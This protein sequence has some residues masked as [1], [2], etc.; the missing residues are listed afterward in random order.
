MKIKKIF[1]IAVLLTAVIF[2]GIDLYASEIEDKFNELLPNIGAADLS[3]RAKA[4]DAWQ[5]ICLKNS[6]DNAKRTEA[7]KLMINQLDKSEVNGETAILFLSILGLVGDQRAVPTI[8]KFLG[9]REIKFVDDAFAKEGNVLLVD[10]AVRALARIPGNQSAVALS[11][12]NSIFARSGQ[13]ARAKKSKVK[14]GVETTMPIAIPYASSREVDRYLRNFASQS[15]VVKTQ[16]I[17]NL[18]VRGDKKYAGLIKQSIKSESNEIRRAAIAAA[19]MVD[20]DDILDML[21]EVLLGDDDV[22]ANAVVGAL[23]IYANQQVNERL[24]KLVE[25]EKDAKRFNRISEVLTN[26]KAAGFLPLLL[27]KLK[28]GVLPDRKS[29]ISRVSAMATAVDLPEFVELWLVTSDRGERVEVE[30]VIARFTNGNA[31]AVIAKQTPENKTKTY[32]LLGRIGDPKTLPMLRTSLSE[33]SADAFNAIREWPDATVAEDLFAIVQGKLGKYSDEDKTNAL[34]AYIRVISLPLDKAKIKTTVEEQANRL[35]EAFSASTRD[36]ER[37]LVIQR[38][39][40]VR[41]VKSLNFVVGQVDE[42]KLSNSA[43]KAILDLAHHA[44]LRRKDADAF[45][46]ALKLVTTKAKDKSF[47]ESANRYLSNF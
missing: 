25:L 18:G 4:Q 23:S 28:S 31:D 24:L 32:P 44:E 3:T 43:F 40:A 13:I 21:V 20:S 46:A 16:I 38:L 10:E 33:T 5:E 12:T 19:V 8:K 29:S 45:K 2:T 42:E 14:I 11:S 1:S 15:D 6:N 37:N 47:I 30:K 36:E 26:R 35:I 17:L 22:L 41:H 34:R 7:V 39:G 9:K 27:S